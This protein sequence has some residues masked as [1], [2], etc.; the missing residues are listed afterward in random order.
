[1]TLALEKKAAQILGSDISLSALRIARENAT[2]LGA[3]VDFV[4][5]DLAA[6]FSSFDVIVSNPPYVPLRD[7]A[8]LQ[9]E[10]RDFEPA[11]AL[12][13][14][15]DGNDVYRKL[16]PAAARAL[17]PG[18]WLILELGDAEAVNG[19]LV[20]WESVA[21]VNDLA[22]IARVGVARTRSD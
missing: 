1:M 9:R 17:K 5:C 13:G 7:R 16:I 22:G 8:G 19:M 21:T 15:K 14:G 4:A 12:F 10:V 18:G 2:R 3:R 6:A 20:R 11:Q